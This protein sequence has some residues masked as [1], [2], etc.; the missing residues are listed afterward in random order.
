MDILYSWLRKRRMTLMLM[1]VDTV[2]IICSAVLSVWC[3]YNLNMVSVEPDMLVSVERYVPFYVLVTLV[4]FRVFHLYSYVW[5][6]AGIHE[7]GVI[8][9]ACFLSMVSQIVGIYIL[10]FRIFRSYFLLSFMFL[11]AMMILVRF[12]SRIFRTLIFDGS[13]LRNAIRDEKDGP[14]I[15]I[16]G[17]GE[18]GNT[19][20][21]TFK[22]S[23]KTEGTVACFVDD[24]PDKIGMILNG[25]SIAGS[26]EDIPR[27][28]E[29]YQ[30]DRIIVA[31]PGAL[32]SERRRII[33]ICRTTQAEIKVLPAVY[34]LVNGEVSVS[35]LRNVQIEDLLGRDQIRT[36]MEEIFRM[37]NGKV[38]L[39]TGGGGS[40]GSEL[41]RQIARHTPGKLVVFDIYENGMYSLQQELNMLVPD[42]QVEYL[43]GSVQNMHRVD[44]IFRTY[45]PD[46]VFHAAAHKHVPLMESSPN[47]AIK[48]NVFGTFN[49]AH[50]ADEFQ[51]RTFVMISTDKA[52]NPT[53]I[54]GASKRICEMIIQMMSRRSSTKFVAVRFGNVLG[55]NGSVVP[56]FRK[57]IERGGPV[58]VTHPDIIRYFMTIPEAVSL[59]LQASFYAQGGEIFVLD[60]GEPVKILDLA[61]NMILLSGYTPDVDIP[62]KFTGLRPGE[63]LYE[64]MLM[65]EEGLQKTPNRQIYIGQP[66]LFNDHRFMSMYRN[67]K[68]AAFEDSA[69][70]REIVASIVPTYQWQEDIT[71]VP[72]RKS[73]NG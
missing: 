28:V 3:R 52:V 34:Q 46:I 32:P 10:H 20:L 13:K 14:A 1:A 40:I 47:E 38:I 15:M 61:R 55:S 23:G 39:V 7:A 45:K 36:N 19:I 2:L 50:A 62:I 48:N 6:S 12:S 25:I 53:N 5:T 9:F 41:C 37:I 73:L 8:V 31:M 57:Q 42:L 56:L 64:E 35:E 29:E 30:I 71:E 49:V 58:T 11:T 33:E 51:T 54:M 44:E 60:M 4:L 72:P 21:R 43:V 24:D 69:E 16:V 68:K 59:V 70:I 66:I 67:L 17:A 18:A 63:K 22:F 65:D 26:T 27:L